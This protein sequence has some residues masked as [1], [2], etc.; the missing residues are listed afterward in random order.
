MKKILFLSFPYPYAKFGPSTNC[1]VRIMKCLIESGKYEVHCCSYSDTYGKKN[2]E[3]VPEIILHQIPILDPRRKVYSNFMIRLKLFLKIPIYPFRTL[4]SDY[5]HYRVC[6][7]ILEK[8]SFDLVVS[9]CYS[10]QSLVAGV[11]LKKHNL[12]KKLMVIF[13]DNIYG[14]VPQKVIPQKF[15]LQRQRKVESWIAKYADKLVS[16]YPINATL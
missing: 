11:L 8:E 10:E 5:H 16:L 4:I 15:A 13:W 1:C 3:E 6:K 14:M 2:F 7:K 12:A 9:Q